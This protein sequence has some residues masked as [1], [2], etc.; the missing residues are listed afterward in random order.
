MVLS[1]APYLSIS[2]VPS[3]ALCEAPLTPSPLARSGAQ[4]YIPLGTQPAFPGL[5]DARRLGQATYRFS[6]P[7]IGVCFSIFLWMFA[8]VLEPL[9]I[10]PQL[11]VFRRCTDAGRLPGRQRALY[12][13][14]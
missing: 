11:L 3:H 14:H 13:Q 2:V 9:A 6:G 10:V 7:S 5:C 4:E 12:L 1:G 8:Q